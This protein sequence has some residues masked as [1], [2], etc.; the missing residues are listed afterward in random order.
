MAA[1]VYLIPSLLDPGG[2]NAVPPAIL[3]AVQCCDTF[4]TE[5][6][7]T[8]RRFLKML[9]PAMEIDRYEWFAIHEAEETQQNNFKKALQAGK[10]IGIISEAGCPGIADPGQLL[11][12]TAQQM[13]VRV[14]PITGPSSIILALMA[15]GM[16]GQQFEFRGYLPIDK[17]D[18]IKKIKELET[19]AQQRKATQIFIE[20]PYRNNQLLEAL[21]AVCKPATLLCVAAGLTGMQESI[22]TRTI[23]EWRKAKPDLHKIPVIY[24]LMA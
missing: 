21:L 10:Q 4:F 5:N 20:T 22:Q 23:A 3:E 6:I 16:N 7:R 1:T 19:D 17:Q 8:T 15:S 11:V 13:G 18:R 9:W 24:L 12:Q 2:I 14:K